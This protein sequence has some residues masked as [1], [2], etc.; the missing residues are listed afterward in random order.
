MTMTDLCGDPERCVR[1]VDN[2][3]HARRR[4]RCSLESRLRPDDDSLSGGFQRQH[5]HRLAV[6][7]SGQPKAT[8][9]TDGKAMNAVVTSE[10]TAVFIDQ[11]A[12]AGSL[13]AR[14]ATNDA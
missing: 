10:D 7:R 1:F 3:V 11:H 6:R 4:Q 2:P 9:L 8:T 5:V 12:A 13:G 14:A